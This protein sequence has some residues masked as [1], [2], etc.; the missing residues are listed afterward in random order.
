MHS[1][2][3]NKLLPYVG[4]KWPGKQSRHREFTKTEIE[5]EMEIDRGSSY[6]DS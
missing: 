6:I 2:V 4:K 1:L 3:A 5:T